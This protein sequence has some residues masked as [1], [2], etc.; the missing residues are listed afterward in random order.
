MPKPAVMCPSELKA[1]PCCGSPASFER[2]NQELGLN[3]ICQ[4]SKCR[5]LMYR[6]RCWFGPNRE[7]LETDSEIED[8]LAQRWNT[9]PAPERHNEL[10]EAVAM[11]LMERPEDLGKRTL[12]SWRELLIIKPQVAH[13]L[14]LIAIEYACKPPY[15]LAEQASPVKEEV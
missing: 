4:N 3:A 8:A 7:R 10:R 6:A 13:F 1:C 12:D 15:A 14:A 2:H 9:S 11:L 5:L